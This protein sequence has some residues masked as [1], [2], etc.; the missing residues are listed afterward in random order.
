MKQ[1]AEFYGKDIET[2]K[3]RFHAFSNCKQ[4]SNWLKENNL[5]STHE[6][7]DRWIAVQNSLTAEFCKLYPAAFKTLGRQKPALRSYGWLL[8]Q[9]AISAAFKK[10]ASPQRF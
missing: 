5:E 3:K 6:I 4:K 9:A 10:T 1:I 8:D 7:I 2:A